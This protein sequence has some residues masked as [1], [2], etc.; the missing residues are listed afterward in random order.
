[1]RK[2]I[3]ISAYLGYSVSLL[4]FTFGIVIIS[5]LAFQYVPV[6]MRVMFGIVLALWGVYR[7]VLTRTRVRQQEENETEEQ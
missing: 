1:M 3:S 5:G 4:T 6:Q 7:F 2:R